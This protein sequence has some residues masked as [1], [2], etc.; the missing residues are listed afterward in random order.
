VEDV[1]ATR[2]RLRE[3]QIRYTTETGGE[4][5]S[6]KKDGTRGSSNRE[7]GKPTV[8]LSRPIAGGKL[9]SQG[10]AVVRTLKKRASGNELGR[11]RDQ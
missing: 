3:D 8:Y 9:R 11:Q 1:H 7:E 6:G 5:C 2:C 4:K 10:I